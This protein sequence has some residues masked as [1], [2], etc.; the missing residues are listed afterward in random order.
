MNDFL[1]KIINIFIKKRPTKKTEINKNRVKHFL[2]NLMSR[3]L[4]MFT[5][6][7]YHKN[8]KNKN[9]GFKIAKYKVKNMYLVGWI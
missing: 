4:M 5:L 9:K 6:R 2:V 7:F 8:C 1:R 3:I